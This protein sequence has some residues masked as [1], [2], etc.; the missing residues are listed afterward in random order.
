[1]STP[2]INLTVLPAGPPLRTARSLPLSLLLP[3]N[4]TVLELKR[5]IAA[6]FPQLRPERQ[7][8][9]LDGDG[10]GEDKEK[11]KGKGKGKGK[12][13]PLEDEQTL[14]SLG[15]DA[16]GEGVVRVK[17]LGPQIG[18][19]TVYVIEYL[20]PLLIHPLFYHGKDLIYRFALPYDHSLLQR[21]TY[22]LVMLHFLKRELETLYLH[23]FSRSTMPFNF[24]FRN[25]AHYWLLSGALV[26]LVVY[27]PSYGQQALEKAGDVALRP[28]WVGGWVTLWVVRLFLPFSSLARSPSCPSLPSSSPFLSPSIPLP[29]PHFFLPILH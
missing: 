23:R 1:M 20:G 3:E 24:V 27:S 15:L 21:T 17:D 18:W 16:G 5:A 10:Q 14:A 9:T 12:K 26:A 13:Q 28:E 2:P 4:T 6:K 8:L 7:R 25:S 29:V 11:G 22:A 19:K